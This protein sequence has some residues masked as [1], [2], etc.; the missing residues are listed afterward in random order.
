MV[1]KFD[2]FS[3]KSYFYGG[4]CTFFSYQNMCK[5]VKASPNIAI[6]V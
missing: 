5:K 6:A 4:G 1:I 3:L 2:K